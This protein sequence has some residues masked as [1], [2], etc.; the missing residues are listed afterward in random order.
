MKMRDVPIMS[1]VQT[2]AQI[3]DGAFMEEVEDHWRNLNR[4]VVETQKAGTLTVT[5]KVEP[6][7]P[8]KP[9]NQ[10]RLTENIRS[11][12]PRTSGMTIV[13]VTETG[14]MSRENPEQG[15]LEFHKEK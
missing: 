8:N 4:H 7:N 6:A 14:D 15:A 9:S 11:S 13:Y 3:D 2:L 1:A 5:L 10:V 12:V